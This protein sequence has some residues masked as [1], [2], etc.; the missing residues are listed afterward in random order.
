MRRPLVA[1]VAALAVVTALAGCSNDPLAE[2][3]LNGGNSNYIAGND[4]L[5][6]KAA[7]RAAPIEFTGETDA[8][9]KLSRSDFAGDVLVVNFWY[10]SCAPCRA[11]APD[12][13]A[14]SQK[15]EGAGASFVGVNIYDG[16]D[17][18]LAFARKFGISYPSLLDSQAGTVR[19]AFAGSISPKAVPT[20]FVLDKQGRIAARILGQLQARSILDTIVGELVKEGG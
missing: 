1:T 8:G 12:L 6:V 15:Y 13:E 16:S 14:L 19:L 18:S 7:D 3:Y 4:I 11:E 20:T 5:E 2:Q 9:V 17:T 10:A